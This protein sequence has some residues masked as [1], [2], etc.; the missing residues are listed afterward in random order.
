MENAQFIAQYE[1]R[2]VRLTVPEGTATNGVL[3]PLIQVSN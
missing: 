2:G 1:L 3:V